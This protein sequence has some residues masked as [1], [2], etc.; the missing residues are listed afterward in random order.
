MEAQQI[1][2]RGLFTLAGGFDE[3]AVFTDELVPGQSAVESNRA[4]QESTAEVSQAAGH[5]TQHRVHGARELFARVVLI[6]PNQA[7]IDPK[8]V[9]RLRRA[10]QL[11]TELRGAA[12][13]A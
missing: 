2:K 3:V 11:Q 10:V 13:G 9:R 8:G 12:L 6:E 5:L 1:A 4:G 7:R